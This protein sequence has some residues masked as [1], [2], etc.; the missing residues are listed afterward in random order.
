MQCNI[1]TVTL[2]QHWSVSSITPLDGPKAGG[3]A[4][5]I[6]GSYLTFRYSGYDPVNVTIYFDGQI[7]PWDFM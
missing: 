2:F 4:V 3:T 7:V 6:K 5:T 1:L